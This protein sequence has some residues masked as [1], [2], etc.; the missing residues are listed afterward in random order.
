MNGLFIRHRFSAFWLR[1]KCSICSYQLNIWYGPQRGPSI[2]NWFLRTGEKLGACSAL[3]T[4]RPGIAVP[5]GLAHFPQHGDTKQNKYNEKI[6]CPSKALFTLNNRFWMNER[7]WWELQNAFPPSSRLR[8]VAGSIPGRVIP[9][10][11]TVAVILRLP[12]LALWVA[13][14]SLTTDWLVSG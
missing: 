1:S 14:L 4:G 6:L 10:T 11:L 12:S 13:G 8:E 7:V 2:L 5:P 3:A 9:N